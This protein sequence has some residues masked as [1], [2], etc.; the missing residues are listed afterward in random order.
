[1]TNGGG[2]V[3]SSWLVDE[4]VERCCKEEEST[5]DNCQI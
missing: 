1:M 5:T 4:I 3:Q 2:V